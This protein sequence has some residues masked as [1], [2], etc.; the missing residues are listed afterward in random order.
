MWE[1]EEDYK[2][3]HNVYFKKQKGCLEIR[4]IDFVLHMISILFGNLC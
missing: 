1:E 3:K 4:F 2:T